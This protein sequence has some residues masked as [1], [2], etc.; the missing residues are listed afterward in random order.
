VYMEPVIPPETR[1]L[2][3]AAITGQFELFD[4]LVLTRPYAQLYYYLKQMYRWGRASKLPPL[5]MYDLMSSRRQAVGAYNWQQTQALITRLQRLAGEE[6]TE[7]SLRTAVAMTDRVR[8]LQRR[9]LACRWHGMLS[10]VDA[11]QVIGAG[12]FMES[13]TYAEALATYVDE[14]EPDAALSGRPR[15][16]VLASEPLSDVNLHQALE[17]AG[18]LVVAEDDWWGARAPGADVPLASSARESILL[19][20]WLDTASSAVLPAEAREAWFVTHA[21]RPDVD[22]VVFY[23]PPSDHQ[24][25][26][27]YPRLR[28]WLAERGKRSIQLRQNAAQPEGRAALTAQVSEWLRSA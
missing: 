9:L 22:G 14:L 24:L 15:L 4:L 25:G 7:S 26:W 27:D 11:L 5:H 6:L 17:D 21:L 23:L 10:G 3:E 20:Y 16:L 8:E 19:K 18:A 12:Y 2:F 13:Q 1:A 28:D